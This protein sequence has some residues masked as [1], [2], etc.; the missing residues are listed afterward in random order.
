MSMGG[1]T[2]PKWRWRRTGWG[3]NGEDGEGAT[4]EEGGETVVGVYNKFFFLKS[5]VLF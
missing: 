2:P 4:V 3:L 5:P 1:L